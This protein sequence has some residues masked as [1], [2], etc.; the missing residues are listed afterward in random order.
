MKSIPVMY[1]VSG[2]MTFLDLTSNVSLGDKKITLDDM[3]AVLK[4]QAPKID[5]NGMRAVL[6]ESLDPAMM[7]V[8]TSGDPFA[9]AKKVTPAKVGDISK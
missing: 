2:I 6:S 8:I 5:P 3:M 1:N 7:A 4:R 9:K